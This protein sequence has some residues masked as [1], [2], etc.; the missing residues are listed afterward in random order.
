M[1]LFEEYESNVRSYCRSFPTIFD[2]AKD[3]LLYSCDGERYIDFFA[4]AGA[5]NYGH[6]NEV[7]K[8]SLLEYVRSDRVI[9]ALDMYTS[10]KKQFMK[11]F[12]E[13][14]LYP[15]NMK[16]KFQFCG[17]TGTNAVEAAFKISR[18][19]KERSGIFSFMGAFH[20]M[21]F[22]SLS[23]TGNKHCRAGSGTPLTGVTFVPYPAGFIKGIDSLEYIDS[24]ISDSHSGIEKPAAIIVE[25]I[26]AE[27][28]VMCAPIEWLKGLR[29][30]CDA[31]D[32]LLI[33]DEIQVGCYRTGSFFSFE[34]AGIVPDIILLSKSLSGYG[35]PFALVLMK[36]ELDIW[37]PGEHNG[38]FRGNQMAFVTA[39]NAIDYAI[40]NDIEGAVVNKAAIIEK[41]LANEIAPICPGIEIR[42]LGLIWGLD[43]SNYGE[44]II[45][46]I[47]ARCFDN[48]LLVEKCGR[49]DLV[50]KIMPPLNIDCDLLMEGLRIIKSVVKFSLFEKHSPKAETSESLC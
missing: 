28:G 30:L 26:Q 47:T 8:Q 3:S 29:A 38:T 2:K 22:A 5:L 43:F 9:H 33:C 11:K 50:L 1:F 7:I 20:G 18:K 12:Q 10:A 31:H 32:I 49:N 37:T 19:V 4:G 13:E 36:P 17:P 14:I 6:N 48:G 27:G 25:T 44:A 42:G 39:A 15:K 40:E 34:R 45:N 24:V 35:L 21:T 16:F 46:Q 23:A 41:F